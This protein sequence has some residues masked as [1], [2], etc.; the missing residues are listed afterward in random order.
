VGARLGLDNLHLQQ[1]DAHELPW[2]DDSFD[3][4]TCRWGVSW[5]DDPR[6]ALAEARRV[7][8]P[9]GRVG[10]VVNGSPN[11]PMLNA[12]HGTVRRSLGLCW[13]ELHQPNPA[14]HSRP[15]SLRD[16]LRAA[17]FA[18]VRERSERV[19]G[20]WSGSGSQVWH[21]AATRLQPELAELSAQQRLSLGR[22]VVA[23]LE[24][25]RRGK[26][27]YLPIHVHL[28]TAKKA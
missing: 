1:G 19:E 14:R 26:V 18:D 6:R 5:F 23:S 25:R 13:P 4:I 10:F 11:Q 27:L 3:L 7:L 22:T 17:G 9:G 15:G 28:G 24:R 2:P 21:L 12:F 8:R 16:D 20:C